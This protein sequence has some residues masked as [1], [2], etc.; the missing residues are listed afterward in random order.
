MNLLDELLALTAALDAAGVDYALVG[1]LA[2]AVWGV[3]RATKDIDLLV[4][5]SPRQRTRSLPRVRASPAAVAARIAEVG[6]ISDFHPDRRMDAKVPM[7]REAVTARLREASDLRDLCLA[8]G[9]SRP[10]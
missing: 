10:A 6:R 8:L 5:P 7:T 4:E 3:P 2:V 9:R 1:R